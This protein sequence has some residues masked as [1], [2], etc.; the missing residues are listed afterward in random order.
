MNAKCRASPLHR[1]VQARPKALDEAQLLEQRGELARRVVPL[2]ARRLAHD[3]RALLVGT[4]AEIAEQPRTNPL[5]LADVHDFSIGGQPAIDARPVLGRGAHAR[6]HVRD[7][8]VGGL[9]REEK[10]LYL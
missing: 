3:A 4:A 1:D 8:L 6:A 10:L 9:R 2:D 7:H 5:R